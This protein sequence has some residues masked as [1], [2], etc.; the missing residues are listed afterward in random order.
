VLVYGKKWPKNLRSE[1]TDHGTLE[2]A[3]DN[4]SCLCVCD[5][6]W[7]GDKCEKEDEYA[8]QVKEREQKMKAAEDK[9]EAATQLNLQINNLREEVEREEAI[10][11][12]KKREQDSR[13]IHNLRTRAQS[14]DMAMLVWQLKTWVYL[15]HS[16]FS[17]MKTVSDKL[18]ALTS[19]RLDDAFSGE[20]AGSSEVVLGTLE[21]FTTRLSKDEVQVIMGAEDAEKEISRMRAEQ[22]QTITKM[23]EVLEECVTRRSEAQKVFTRLS[24]FTSQYMVSSSAIE[25]AKSAMQGRLTEYSLAVD[26]LYGLTTALSDKDTLAPS[27]SGENKL[28][29]EL[30][31][32]AAEHREVLKMFQ[33][34]ADSLKK[35]IITAV[36]EL[37][38]AE[39]AGSSSGV[40][41]PNPNAGILSDATASVTEDS[42]DDGTTRDNTSDALQAS[43]KDTP[44]PEPQ[45]AESAAEGEGEGE[46][47]GEAE[48]QS[49]HSEGTGATSVAN[50]K[51]S[52]AS[53]HASDALQASAKDTPAPEPQSAESATEGEGE[54][55]GEA[56]TQSVHSEGT[57]ATSVANVKQ[58]HASAHASADVGSSNPEPEHA[59]SNDASGTTPSKQ[60]SFIEQS[61][62]LELTAACDDGETQRE[63]SDFETIVL[64][65]S[66]NKGVADSENQFFTRVPT[67]LDK[68]KTVVEKGVRCIVDDSQKDV[69]GKSSDD[70][71]E[72]RLEHVNRIV[73]AATK[74][75]QTGMQNMSKALDE[76]ARSYKDFL[77]EKVEGLGISS[78]DQRKLTGELEHL[79]TSAAAVDVAYST[80]ITA[81][82]FF[83]QVLENAGTAA[84]KDKV[85][86][87][88]LRTVLMPSCPRLDFEALAPLAQNVVADIVEEEN[89][90]AGALAE[91]VQD[92]EQE[93]IEEGANEILETI[94]RAA[95]T[96]ADCEKECEEKKKK[97]E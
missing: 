35:S 86:P 78:E 54:G 6:G 21:E 83:C 81:K 96:A 60:T 71:N 30:S 49:V 17:E 94:E 18:S 3:K 12:E 63:L 42:A 23:K 43:A 5:E 95:A 31:K 79:Q 58:S 77:T 87:D 56:E 59:D 69:W 28:F 65:L 91:A 53:A 75:A 46:G 32:R 97:G 13:E 93:A 39:T 73:E 66:S 27:K 9:A 44:A 70:T 16:K 76:Q 40:I 41:D 84:V 45:S 74:E 92:A 36:E 25:E 33:E 61:S 22:E 2:K 68:F 37:K 4:S 80:L 24:E 19:R 51:Q 7:V 48:T 47:E 72:L 67:A 29:E 1:C 50:V 14:D 89:A 10:I 62:S 88:A 34:E 64:E 57:G 82:K 90:Q 15:V 85:S 8:K 20:G 26:K 52:H 11:Q 55:E 38:T